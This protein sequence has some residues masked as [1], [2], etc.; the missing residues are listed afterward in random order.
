MKNQDQPEKRKFPTGYAEEKS[1]HTSQAAGEIAPTTGIKPQFFDNRY[2]GYC[3][4]D[5]GQVEEVAVCHACD[6][7]IVQ[8]ADDE[9]RAARQRAMTSR[10]VR[11]ASMA[12]KFS[13]AA[14]LK[15]PL[16]CQRDLLDKWN[17]S[18]KHG[19]TLTGDGTGKSWLIWLLLKKAWAEG[20]EFH[21]GIATEMKGA[22]MALARNGDT[23]PAI[24][25]LVAYPILAIDDFGLASPSPAAD[26]LWAK[27][28][29]MRAKAQRPT[30]IATPYDGGSVSQRFS[31]PTAGKKIT[32]LLG[33]S[34]GWVL[35]TKREELYAPKS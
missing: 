17:P 24:K 21:A 1:I 32:K 20:R 15:L 31:D 11:W 5:F 27:L 13:T 29:E 2:C 14:P 30:L 16:D 4:H 19:V 10:M 26:E 23:T 8:K 22:I 33:T 34:N 3:N 35:D 18:L 12:G 28:L 7:K 6:A 25:K 9:D